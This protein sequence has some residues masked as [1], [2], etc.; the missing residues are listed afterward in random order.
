MI[1]LMFFSCT[2]DFKKLPSIS[3]PYVSE[4]EF[5]KSIEVNDNKV[6]KTKFKNGIKYP[7]ILF[8]KL[9]EINGSGELSI[10]IY[11]K[12]KKVVHKKNFKFGKQGKYYEYIILWE[13]IMKLE[14]R[15]FYYAIFYNEDLIREGMFKTGNI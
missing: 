7:F 5:L 1:I 13:R 4:I 8:V 14:G 6:K 10:K 12:Q 9:E 11:N 3:Y 15:D 2:V